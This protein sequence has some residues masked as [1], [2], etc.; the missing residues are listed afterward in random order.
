MSERLYVDFRS[1]FDAGVKRV[2]AAVGPRYNRGDAGRVTSESRYFLDYGIEERTVDGRFFM[3]LDVV[4]HDTEESFCIL[5]QFIFRGNDHATSE[6][7]ELGPDETLKEYVLVA[8]AR[9]FTVNP[10]RIILNVG[11]AVRARFDIQ[12]ADSVGRFDVE[13]RVKVLGAPT[14]STSLFDVGA[15]F[16][17]VCETMGISAGGMETSM[18]DEPTS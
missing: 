14:L 2:L 6:Q 5:S 3:Q 15:I 10:A 7:F 12:D 18:P 11:D 9:E 4:S 8:C 13:V 1:D 17:Q 16:G